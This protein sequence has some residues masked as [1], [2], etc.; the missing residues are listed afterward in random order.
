MRHMENV[1]TRSEGT[2]HPRPKPAGA[3]VR[4]DAGWNKPEA[5]WN[6]PDKGYRPPF[7]DSAAG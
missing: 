2:R 1:D 4:R 7:T 3:A 6:R 5:G